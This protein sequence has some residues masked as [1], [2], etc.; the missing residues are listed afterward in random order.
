M[1]A[2]VEGSRTRLPAGL[3]AE[4]PQL[5][6]LYEMAIILFCGSSTGASPAFAAAARPTG[7][8]PGVPAPQTPSRLRAL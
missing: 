8:A 2:V 4:L 5:R 1:A 6:W 3:Q 7:E